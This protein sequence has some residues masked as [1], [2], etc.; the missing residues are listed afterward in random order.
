MDPSVVQK[1]RT[2]AIIAHPD[3][4]KTTLTEKLLLYGG[5]INLAGHVRAKRDRK[6]TRSDWMKLE[7]ER[8]ISINTS[9]M[10][11]E[12]NGYTLNLLDT[13]G[14]EDFSE[15]TYRTL[16][17][18][19]SAIMILDGGRGVEP[20]TIKLFNICKEKRIPIIT[21][22]NKLDMP[23]KESFEIMDEIESVLGITCVPFYWPMGSGHLFKGIYNLR[24]PKLHRFEK[25]T[26]GSFRAPEKV[27]SIDD[28]ELVELMGERDYGKFREEVEI[29]GELLP[30][31]D[32]ELF[33]STEI[34]PVFFG[35]AIN[36]FGIQI[37]LDNFIDLVPPPR[38]VT[39]DSGERIE[40]VEDE[41]R[42]FVFKLQANMNKAHRDRVAFARIISG[43]FERGMQVK[44]ARLNK[45]VKLSSPVTFFGQERSTIDQ[46]FPG[47]II[48]LINPGIYKIGDLLYTGKDFDY[49]PLPV[50]SPEAFASIVLTDTSKSKAFKKGLME[51]AEEG[52]VQV[53]NLD[54]QTPIVGGIG[55]L[56]F[57]VFSF[58]LMDEYGAPVRVEPMGFDC[59]RWIDP[60]Q[61]LSIFSRFDKI[62]YD[63][64]KNPI[65][66]FE[67]EYRL[68]NFEA[69]N[70]D[71]KLFVHPIRHSDQQP[72]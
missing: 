25:Q 65:V 3:A 67:T 59:S 58:R 13:P 8:G 63:L 7:Q 14:H 70:P 41:F 57:E 31:F 60:E 62:V 15:D 27:G 36:N 23:A 68:R 40:P 4:G 22:V 55:Q 28:P 47:D 48:G 9:V 45:N 54:Q 1:R 66:L 16:M 44:V 6:S 56:Q 33:L 17:A 72:S 24:E 64:D 42:A 11:F 20:Q 71:V 53:F 34:T 35:S 18:A 69:D 19:E 46:A 52:V 12:Y 49:T 21:F 10:Q 29:A 2:F 38:G 32:R 5:A 26:S 43:T 50:F 51:L 61:D 37:L 30:E 39:L